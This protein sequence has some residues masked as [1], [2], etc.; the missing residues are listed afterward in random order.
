MD[1][2]WNGYNKYRP[3]GISQKP[4]SC[5]LIAQNFIDSHT[6]LQIPVHTKTDREITILPKN[7]G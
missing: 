1:I 5:V 7:G 6:I 3:Q 2:I 4:M